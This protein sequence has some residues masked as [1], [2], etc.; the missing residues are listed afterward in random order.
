MNYF[1]PGVYVQEIARLPPSVVPVATAIPAFVGYTEKGAGSIE[2]VTSLLEFREKFGGPL[3]PDIAVNLAE[4]GTVK[5]VEMP[6]LK[7]NLYYSMLMYF[8][9]GGGRCYVASVGGYDDLIGKEAIVKGLQMIEAEDEPTLLVIPDAVNTNSAD[10]T[11]GSYQQALAQCAKLQDRF[12]LLDVRDGDVDGFRNGVGNNNLSYGAAYHPYLKTS[13]NLEY[14]ENRVT[15]SGISDAGGGGSSEPTILGGDPLS[16]DEGGFGSSSLSA[17]SS[18][19]TMGELRDS[20]K[21]TALYNKV[22]LALQDMRV[23]LPPSAA[24]AGIYATVDR[25]RGVWKAPANIS[26]SEV[27]APSVKISHE[28]QETLNV[29]A[30]TGKSINAI[31]GFAGKGT[32]VWGARTLA[33]NDNEWRYVNVRRLFLMIEESAKKATAF[34]VFEANNANTWLKVQGMIE[35]FLYNLWDQGALFGSTPEQ[36]YS[37]QVGLNKTMTQQDVLEGRMIVEIAVA[38]VRPAE[39]IVLRFMHKMLEA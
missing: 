13:L 2:E 24:V 35:A 27:K 11:W 15:I 26:L 6:A 5:P 38:A 39:F 36:A 32:L 23:E 29:H 31:R 7:F 21:N 1:T 33:G 28:E 22:K 16:G 20:S 4:D 12:A 34:A 14:D 17:G 19:Q 9:N 3:V 37:V 10:D 30:D 25:T 8:R 18:T